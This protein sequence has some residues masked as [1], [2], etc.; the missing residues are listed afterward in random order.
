MPDPG[1]VGGGVATVIGTL[2][3]VETKT[4]HGLSD[5]E[6]VRIGEGELGQQPPLPLYYAKCSGYPNNAFA[7]YTDA[8][9]LTPAAIGNVSAG[10]T[11][12]RLA[13]EDW[14]VVA[15][16]NGY[17][18]YATL[19]GAV[20]DANRFAKWLLSEA[21]VPDD[22][23]RLVCSQVGPPASLETAQP[24]LDRVKGQFE[25][26]ARRAA[27]KD[28]YRLGRRLYIFLSGHG[29]LPT[30][31]ALPNFN[32]TALLM[33]D[34]D[35]ITIGN[36]VGGN[37]YAEWFRA[38]GVFDEVVLFLD[39]CRDE[40]KNIGL[41]PPSMPFL[42]RQRA[43]ARRFYAAATQMDSQSW[44]RPFGSPP[45]TRGV[46][47]YALLEALNSQSL[48]DPNGLLTGKILAG[49]LYRDVPNLQNGQDPDI[50]YRLEQ[51]I[52]FI[53]RLDPKKPKA[54]IT[55]APGLAGKTVLLIGKNYPEPDVPPYV[56]VNNQT[57]DLV[58]DP[59]NYK[60]Q[61]QGSEVKKNFEVDGKEE[62]L[63]V[64]FP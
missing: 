61:L 33:A 55:F 5:G 11:V 28:F 41:T 54:S 37:A 12:V 50:D 1:P 24:T 38:C 35:S 18:K 64:T 19:K 40:M 60:L 20:G 23:L 56:I 31:S 59:F 22:Q 34:V 43:P 47:S 45:E 48:C 32:E 42:D 7:A 6:R 17:W 2:P 63:N 30:R 4:A 27:K 51:D 44:E 16:I 36:H 29:I 14:A 53:R 8:A 52:T 49:Q 21:L 13:A 10:T 25:D 3:V 15:G 26:L 39:C 57:W 58:L 46:F 9:L 62:K